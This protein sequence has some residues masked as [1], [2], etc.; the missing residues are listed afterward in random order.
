MAKKQTRNQS[1]AAVENVDGN[2]D[3]IREILFGG[4]MRDY[5]QRFADLEK[6]LG[7]NIERIAADID[8]RMDR[9]EAFA[10][11]EVEKIAEQLKEERKA[12]REEGK[13]GGKELK[14]LAGEIES[15]C[16]ELEEQI[17]GETQE[18]RDLLVEQGEQF[19]GMIGETHSQLSENLQA[20]TRSMAE[21]SVARDDLAS[22]LAD[23]AARLKKSD[24]PRGR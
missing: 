11:R 20:E 10:R 13:R 9:L 2:V 3:K 14:E 1:G 21:E 17:G 18:I 19:T 5:E 22:L 8:K 15:R 7:K 12:R 23:V 24:K 4:Q 16:A 6:R